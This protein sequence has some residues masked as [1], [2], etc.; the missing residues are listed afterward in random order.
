MWG[1]QLH[2]ANFH[3]KVLSVRNFVEETGR[4]TERGENVGAPVPA[5]TGR[6]TPPSSTRHYLRPTTE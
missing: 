6:A 5:S 3:R 4:T 1:E 2:A